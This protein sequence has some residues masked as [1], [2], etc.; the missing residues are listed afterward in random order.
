MPYSS[1]SSCNICPRNCGIDR[2]KHIGYCG[3]T[4]TL[5]VDLITRHFGEEPPLTGTRGSGTIFFSGCNLRCVFCQNYD[6]SSNCWGK[7]ITK[8]ELT[9]LMF[10]LQTE[11]AHNINLVTP[12]HFTRQLRE[13]IFYAK[14]E[15]LA[16]PIVWN[17]SAYEKVETLQSLNGLVDIY[18]PDFKY[19]H[20]VYARKYSS[21]SDYP[22]IAI[23]AIK[24]M[25]SQVGFL[26]V[27]SNGIAKKGII[28]RMLVLPYGLAGCKENLYTLANEIGVDLTLSIMG[29]YYPAGK[30]NDYKELRR[31]ISPK[32]YQDVI[33]TAVAL[34][35][36]NIYT[37]EISGSEL[38]TP[39]F[40]PEPNNVYGDSEFNPIKE[41][42][43]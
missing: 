21:A 6:I 13:A 9:N 37:Q 3:V 28:I 12:T 43:I 5:K 41:Q 29:Q 27:D 24:E 17:S 15:G 39:D 36:T 30:A 31:G 10:K 8:D 16:I 38:W 11:G 42:T 32:E 20:K 40:S 35:F 22:A 33:E 14:K 4:D 23:S 2:T 1:M 26:E 18:L 34:G 19:A 7:D 25:F